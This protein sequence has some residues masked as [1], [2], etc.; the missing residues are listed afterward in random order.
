MPEEISDWTLDEGVLSRTV[1]RWDEQPPMPP[2]HGGG[3]PKERIRDYER[4]RI[5]RLRTLGYT[6]AEIMEETGRNTGTIASV[7]RKAKKDGLLPCD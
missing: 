2:G 7:C 4:R 6:M 1:S 3:E 5:I